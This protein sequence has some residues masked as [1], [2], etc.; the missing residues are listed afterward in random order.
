[1]VGVVSILESVRVREGNHR[2]FFQTSDIEDRLVSSRHTSPDESIPVLGWGT[3]FM[4]VGE[5][6]ACYTA[7]FDLGFTCA[8]PLLCSS[9]LV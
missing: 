8:R 6:L 4:C 3:P 5:Y 1:M 9:L 7:T 2:K